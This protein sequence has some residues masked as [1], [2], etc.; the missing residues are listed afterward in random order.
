[1]AALRAEFGAG[2]QFGAAFGTFIILGNLGTA[3]RAEFHLTGQRFVT[4]RAGGANGLA[5]I[6]GGEVFVFFSH[7]GVRPDFFNRAGGLRSRHFYPKIWGAI[8]A[9]AAF[10]VPA[11]LAADPG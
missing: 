4:S 6:L 11:G 9:Q 10:G 8:F 5:K 2:L 3:V 1:M 7:G